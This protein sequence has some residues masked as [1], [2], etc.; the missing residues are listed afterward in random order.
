MADWLAG[1]TVVMRSSDGTEVRAGLKEIRTAMRAERF[2]EL[3]E[4]LVLA[5]G[6][7]RRQRAR[8]QQAREAAIA[9]AEPCAVIPLSRGVR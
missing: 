7:V 8:R 9:A 2:D 5:V 6:E 3:L 4:D 1:A